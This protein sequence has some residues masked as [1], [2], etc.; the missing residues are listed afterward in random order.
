MEHTKNDGAD[1]REE[2]AKEGAVSEEEGTEFFGDSE[3]TMA[4]F[5]V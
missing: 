3:D 4:V 5:H 1:G 2:A